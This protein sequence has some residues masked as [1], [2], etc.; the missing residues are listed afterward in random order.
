MS[1]EYEDINERVRA[2]WQAE[3]TPFERVHE[4]IEQTDAGQ[5]AAEIA[6][7][8]LVSEPT[9]RQHCKALVNTGV[10][11]TEQEGQTTRYRRNTDHV[12]TSRIHEL[13]AETTRS[14]LVESIA[15]MKAEVRGYEEEYDVLSPE[16]LARDLDPEE[17]DGWEDLTDWQTTRKHLALAQAALAYDEASQHLTA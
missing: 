9:A 10:A 8:A 14:Q 12:L 2:E 1:D 4:V 16:E 7:R 13:R 15:E 17:T 5:S 6:E 3:T 11:E